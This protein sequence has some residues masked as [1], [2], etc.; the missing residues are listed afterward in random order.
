MT[1][2]SLGLLDLQDEEATFPSILGFHHQLQSPARQ[3]AEISR[4]DR[5]DA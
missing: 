2:S 4:C 3:D 1:P 5:I